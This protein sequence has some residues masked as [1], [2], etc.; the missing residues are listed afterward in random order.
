M[1]DEKAVNVNRFIFNI[2]FSL[3]VISKKLVQKSDVL[4]I[5]IGINRLIIGNALIYCWYHVFIMNSINRY[6]GIAIML[7]KIMVVIEKRDVVLIVFK[8]PSVVFVFDNKGN[9][10]VLIIACAD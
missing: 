1:I 8:A 3:F 7:N 9:N 4:R 6:P 5:A 2:F 10:E